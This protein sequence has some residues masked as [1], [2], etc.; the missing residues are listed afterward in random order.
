[1]RTFIS[2]IALVVTGI[3]AGAFLSSTTL[4]MAMGIAVAVLFL[5][6]FL[7]F[8]GPAGTSGGLGLFL[9]MGVALVILFVSAW[10]SYLANHLAR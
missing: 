6:G 4:L 2:I 1:M 10:V 8:W 7:P 9:L 5:L 3:F